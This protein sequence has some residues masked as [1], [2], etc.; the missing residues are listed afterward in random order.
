MEMEEQFR[1]ELEKEQ[2]IFS[3]AH[4]ITFVDADGNTICEQ[5]HG[6][7]YR[8]RCE[9]FGSLNEHGYVVDFI[10]LRDTLANLVKQ[11]DHKMLVATE[12]PTI[13]VTDDQREVTLSFE[14]RRWVFPRVDCVLLPTSNTTAEL[15]ARHLCD[16]LI[17]SG[18][19]DGSVTKV[20]VSVDENEGQW[21]VCAKSL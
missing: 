6:H 2:L 1:V 7:N 4:F 12:H 17:E 20:V 14:D 5:L 9:V 10:A 18:V 11:F 16:R 3:A 8:V 15:L 19:M 21:G 13:K